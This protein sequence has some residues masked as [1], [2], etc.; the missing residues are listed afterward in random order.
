M[1]PADARL[2]LWRGGVA[3]ALIV[4][5]AP[6]GA[7]APPPEALR[8]AERIALFDGII[9]S[10]FDHRILKLEDDELDEARRLR[11]RARAYCARGKFGFGIAAIDVALERIGALPLAGAD[12][13]PE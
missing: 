12:P 5:A 7:Q 1:R 8:C 3:A 4:W 2:A 11:R 10:R 9:Q 6:A 13:P